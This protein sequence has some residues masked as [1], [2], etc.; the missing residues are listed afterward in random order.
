MVAGALGFA[1]TESSADGEWMVRTVPG[2]LGRKTYR[3]PGCDQEI[4]PGVGHLVAWP[5]G[6][7]GYDGS[8]QRRHWHNPCWAARRRRRPGHRRGY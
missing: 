6:T 8:G 3:C 2:T 5:A 1:R 7:D 4:A